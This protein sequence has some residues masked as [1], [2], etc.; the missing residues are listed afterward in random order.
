MGDR[1]V[2]CFAEDLVTGEGDSGKILMITGPAT[3]TPISLLS[4]MRGV[5]T[6]GGTG[7]AAGDKDSFSS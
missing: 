1:L 5:G 4:P 6:G 2:D 7:L 3:G